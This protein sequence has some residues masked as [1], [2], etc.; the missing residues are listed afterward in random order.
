MCFVRRLREFGDPG[1]CAS[2]WPSSLDTADRL[3][4]HELQG[5]E[6]G[7][8]TLRG[9]YAPPAG[10]VRAAAEAVDLAA[11]ARQGAAIVL[12]SPDATSTDLYEETHATRLSVFTA[13]GDPSEATAFDLVV[14]TGFEPV[15]PP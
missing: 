7:A 10:T 8:R 12:E 3:E 4:R 1:I 15:S 5:C 6:V 2:L 14:P 13:C 11:V 9:A